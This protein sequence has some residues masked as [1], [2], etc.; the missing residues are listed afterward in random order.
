M[1]SPIVP[2][3]DSAN[4]LKRCS[5]CGENKSATT[6]FFYSNKDASDGLSNPCKI[7]RQDRQ[8][9]YAQRPEVQER[10][11][12]Y[13]AT[14]EQQPDVKERRR[15]G[16]REYSNRP[17]VRAKRLQRY[18]SE[19]YRA[20]HR[21]YKRRPE[22]KAQ[23]RKYNARP[24]VAKRR[25]ERLAIYWST[26]AFRQKNKLK[27]Q[28]RRTREE[29]LPVAYSPDDWQRA[30][31][32]FGGCC[33]VCGRQPG[34]WNVIAA[35]HWIPIN[36]DSCP[37]TVPWNIVPLCH[38]KRGGSG[39]CNNSKRDKPAGEW[40]VE[41]YGKRKGAAILRRIEVYLESRK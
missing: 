21:E 15:Q 14:V 17:D 2:N 23:E 4:H 3:P 35:D 5:E 18:K 37:G 13:R 1:T 27:R 32:F 16:D 34:L 26:E 31:D 33:A 25:S 11:R 22:Y 9:R 20:Q 30:L 8:R 12:V 40:L 28:I 41:K 29:N 10:I 6:E 36:S 38:D 24:D 19:E 39:G 7:C